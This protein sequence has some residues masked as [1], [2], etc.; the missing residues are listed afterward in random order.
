MRGLPL[1]NLQPSSIMM[2]GGWSTGSHPAAAGII[3]TGKIDPL[4]GRQQMIVSALPHFSRASVIFA[5][6]LDLVVTSIRR[7]SRGEPFLL[8][9]A[10]L[11]RPS[12]R[13]RALSPRGR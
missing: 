12:P 4:L 9:T 6:V 8:P 3:V 13:C 1:V 2:G 10:P 5:P 7:M 11:P